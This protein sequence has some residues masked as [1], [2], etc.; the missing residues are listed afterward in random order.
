L[1]AGATYWLE[2]YGADTEALR[3]FRNGPAPNNDLVPSGAGATW[4]DSRTFSGG[5]WGGS[6]G[7]IN[8][9]ELHGTQYSAVP[10]PTSFLLVAGVA[11]VSGWRRF[12]RR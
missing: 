10:E 4:Q 6:V 2:V 7:V 5:S 9:F 12:R 1:Q 3:W 11:A 8:T